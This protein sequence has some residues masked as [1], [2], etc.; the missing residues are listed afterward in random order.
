VVNV[1]GTLAIEGGGTV[2]LSAIG[3]ALPPGRITLF[4]FGELTGEANLTGW[5]V[6]GAGLESKYV[7]IRRTPDSLVVTISPRG[8]LISIF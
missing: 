3:G 8:T 2:E 5:T 6:T 4:S 1:T 7:R